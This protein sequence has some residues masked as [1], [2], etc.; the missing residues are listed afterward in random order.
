MALSMSHDVIRQSTGVA[1]YSL[2]HCPSCDK[3]ASCCQ[4]LPKFSLAMQ[5]FCESCSER[6]TVC[7]ECALVRSHFKSQ[8]LI[9]RHHRSSHNVVH[10]TGSSP[11]FNFP[12]FDVIEDLSLTLS[13]RNVTKLDSNQSISSRTLNKSSNSNYFTEFLQSLPCIDNAVNCGNACSN[14]FLI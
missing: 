2:L 10:S 14:I 13:E 4:A 11:Q 1:P 7:T 9:L 6:W 5:L 8:R 3:Y 12:P